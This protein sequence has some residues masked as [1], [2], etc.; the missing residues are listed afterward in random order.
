M[1]DSGRDPTMIIGSTLKSIHEWRYVLHQQ[2]FLRFIDPG[3]SEVGIALHR[4]QP[5]KVLSADESAIVCD[6]FNESVTRTRC[7]QQER[8][9][10]FARAG[11]IRESPNR[12]QGRT[13]C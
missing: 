11:S 7:W 5:R 9:Q 12:V 4:A 6:L 1:W 8:Q 13:V 2:K 10:E 3:K